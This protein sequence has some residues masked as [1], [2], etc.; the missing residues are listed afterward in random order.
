MNAPEAPT[1]SAPQPVLRGFMHVRGAADA[2]AREGIEMAGKLVLHDLQPAAATGKDAIRSGPGCRLL[3]HT[4][5]V[6]M[7][8]W[9][10]QTMPLK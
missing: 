3:P 9:G 2:Y 4:L 1:N 7:C 6:R 10:Q 8:V 5:L